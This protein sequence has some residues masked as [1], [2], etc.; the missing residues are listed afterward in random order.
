MKKQWIIL[1]AIVMLAILAIFQ[2][3]KP[4]KEELSKVKHIAPQ[5]S[6]TGLDGKIYTLED[7]NGKP[8]VVNFWASWC[9]P[10]EDEAPELVR[11]YEKYSE[12]VEIYAVNVTTSD[13]VKG[14]IAFAEK[15]GF[16]FPVLLDIE[17][18]VS[19]KYRIQSFPTTYFING[20]GVIVEKVIGLLSPRDLERK[21]KQLIR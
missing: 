3:S 6:L 17:G 8:V 10:C 18:T 19:E 15:Y 7:L 20:E 2:T 1:V 11:L 13:S 12:K 5:I 16:E 9:G 21:S 14:A 4:N